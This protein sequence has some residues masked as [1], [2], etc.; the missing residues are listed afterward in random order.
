MS[1]LDSFKKHNEGE[2]VVMSKFVRNLVIT[3]LIGVSLSGIV[4]RE[5]K[6]YLKDLN[7]KSLEAAIQRG[8]TLEEFDRIA[9]D[10]KR[11]KISILTDSYVRDLRKKLIRMGLK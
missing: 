10:V 5:E 8:L 1:S 4:D 11:E 6:L 3:F 2:Y 9:L 7:L